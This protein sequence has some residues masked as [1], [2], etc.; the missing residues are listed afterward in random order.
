MRTQN[1]PQNRALTRSWLLFYQSILRSL[2]AQVAD[3]QARPQVHRAPSP[4]KFLS[5]FL[6]GGSAR[7]PGSPTKQRMP[8]MDNI[9]KILPLV[10]KSSRPDMKNRP[11]TRSVAS[12][13][14]A[15]LPK[16]SEGQVRPI[17][18]LEETFAVYVT[19]LHG[20]RGAIAGQALRSRALADELAI[21]D[22]YNRLC[23][24][25]SGDRR[26]I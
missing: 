10:R 3:S 26:G 1:Q 6:S 23:R 24:W 19:A 14:D 15:V 13:S 9:P 8:L 21:N 4:V 12:T 20:R 16:S 22:V 7:E 25:S 18:S 17:K 5:N 11:V 2:P